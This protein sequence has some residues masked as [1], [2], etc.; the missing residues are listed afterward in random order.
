MSQYSSHNRVSRLSWRRHAVVY[1]ALM[2][3]TSP[4]W[5]I[6]P[7][8]VLKC[9]ESTQRKKKTTRAIS[10]QSSKR[11]KRMYAIFESRLG[12]FHIW[13]SVKRLCTCIV[14]H[15]NSTT[16]SACS[17]MAGMEKMACDRYRPETVCTVQ[18]KYSNRL[19]FGLIRNAY[20]T[21]M[22]TW[23]CCNIFLRKI[24]LPAVSSSHCHNHQRHY[25][26]NCCTYT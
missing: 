4:G 3:S 5:H 14:W 22:L 12:S 11:H 13:Y 10:R 21:T 24:K 25:K 23:C 18:C 9:P 6:W 15:V 17:C 8:G 1:L 19:E 2:I 16:W 7:A 26:Y 20:R